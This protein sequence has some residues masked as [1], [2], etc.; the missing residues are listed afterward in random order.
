MPMLVC[1]MRRLAAKSPGPKWSA[2]RRSVALAIASALVRPSA[3]SIWA[4]SLDLAQVQ[5]RRQLQLGQEDGDGV[6]VFGAVHFGDHDGVEGIAGRFDHLD[7]VPVEVRR[8]EG[9]GPEERRATAPVELLQGADDVPA[10]AGLVVGG[11]GVF[12]VEEDGVGV[13]GERLLDHLPLG[14]GDGE[15]GA[16]GPH[17]ICRAASLRARRA[18]RR[19]GPPWGGPS[20]CRRGPSS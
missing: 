12:E 19:R 1:G 9:V 8:V 7:Q 20:V 10:G 6:E 2:S 13:R 17:A 5:V 4:S 15:E 3:L 16:G 18:G 14:G 11:D